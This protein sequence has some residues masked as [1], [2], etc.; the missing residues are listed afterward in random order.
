ME[1]FSGET[2]L[3]LIGAARPWADKNTC[4]NSRGTLEDVMKQYSNQR[5][6]EKGQTFCLNDA[7]EAAGLQPRMESAPPW[8]DS[9][10][11]TAVKMAAMNT[12]ET[13]NLLSALISFRRVVAAGRPELVSAQ[14][15]VGSR[16][17]AGGG[18]R[19][20]AGGPEVVSGWVAA[21][22]RRWRPDG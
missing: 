17:T 13:A 6:M 1:T 5:V 7:S 4:I 20:A 22:G 12:R 15:R 18:G 21:G 8:C 19:V 9:S 11:A 10:K 14:S 16:R 3:P 2:T